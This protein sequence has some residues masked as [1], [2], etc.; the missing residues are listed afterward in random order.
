[1]P[2]KMPEEITTL[3]TNYK[4][5]L[6][7]K[8]LLL[9]SWGLGSRLNDPATIVLVEAKP[10][11]KEVDWDTLEKGVVTFNPATGDIHHISFW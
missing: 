1:M 11:P 4:N 7:A 3:L 9:C 10:N 2:P 6:G 5:N 8:A